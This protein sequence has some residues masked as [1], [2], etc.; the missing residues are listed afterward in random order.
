MR[1]GRLGE[2]EQWDQLAHAHLAG[3]LAEHV[4][5]LESDRVAERLGDRGHPLGLLALDVGVYD[6]LAAALTRRALLLGRELQTHSHR[7]TNINSSDDCQSLAPG[8][9]D[10]GQS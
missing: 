10:S 9:G 3:V 5:Q 6:R 2:L 7:Y 1:D 4:H 8:T